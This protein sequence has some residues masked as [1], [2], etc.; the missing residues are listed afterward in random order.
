MFVVRIKRCIK[1][2]NFEEVLISGPLCGI[3]YVKTITKHTVRTNKSTQRQAQS[4]SGY[5]TVKRP[6]NGRGA[7]KCQSNYTYLPLH[8]NI[9]NV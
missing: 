1:L 3:I 4:T 8:Y 6:T 2:V 9:Y 7:H 5:N